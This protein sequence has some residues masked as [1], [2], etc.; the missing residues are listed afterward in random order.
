[1]FVLRSTATGRGGRLVR[2]SSTILVVVFGLDG[3]WTLSAD[4]SD[5]AT[6]GL[7]SCCGG[8]SRG[9]AI[10]ARL[11]EFVLVPSHWFV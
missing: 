4:A 6:R 1:M 9:Y 8:A 3:F 7:D 11:R 5:A 10:V 2:A